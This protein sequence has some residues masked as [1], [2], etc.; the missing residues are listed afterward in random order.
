MKRAKWTRLIAR[1]LFLLFFF[2]QKIFEEDQPISGFHE[3]IFFRG[4]RLD[5]VPTLPCFFC[6]PNFQSEEQKKKKNRRSESGGTRRR[7]VPRSSGFPEGCGRTRRNRR[8]SSSLVPPRNSLSLSLRRQYRSLNHSAAFR[9]TFGTADGQ[10]RL[11]A[12]PSTSDV[13]AALNTWNQ[14]WRLRRWTH[15]HQW[16]RQILAP[17]IDLA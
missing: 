3:K 16:Q 1:N 12:D 15:R 14:K 7:S 13:M 9:F 10:L 5:S 11:D 17:E 2:R 6:R 8:S 4:I